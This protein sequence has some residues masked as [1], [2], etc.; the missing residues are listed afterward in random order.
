MQCKVM[1]CD[2]MQRSAM[3]R[4]VNVMQHDMAM[5]PGSESFA[6]QE[7]PGEDGRVMSFFVG[8]KT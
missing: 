6:S 4:K 5:I 7:M 3:Q 2:V 8:R 1:S